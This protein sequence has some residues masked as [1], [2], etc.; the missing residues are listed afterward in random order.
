MNTTPKTRPTRENFQRIRRAGSFLIL[1]LLTVQ[2]GQTVL[3]SPPTFRSGKIL[4]SAAS[5]SNQVTTLQVSESPAGPWLDLDD[6]PG[7]GQPI[8]F[9]VT[10]TGERRFFRLRTAASS[11]FALSPQTPTLTTGA[12]SLPD[13]V[14]GSSYAENISTAATGTPPYTFQ[15]SGTPPDGVTLLLVSNGTANAFL[16]ISA[17]GAGA[18]A[19]QRRQFTVSALDGA[20]ALATNLYDLRVIEPPPVILTTSILLK[21]GQDFTTSLRALHGTGPLDWSA[22]SEIM[23]AGSSLSATGDLSGLPSPDDAEFEET[24]RFTNMVMVT[25]S[26]TDRISG[27]PAPRSTVSAVVVTVRLSY[28]QNIWA[29]RPNGPSLGSICYFCHGSGFPP[30]VTETATTLIGMGS[31]MGSI[32]A[33]SNQVYVVPGNP[34]GS[35]VWKKLHGPD[36]GDRMPQ[37][38]PYLEAGAIARVERWIRELTSEDID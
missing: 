30:D 18:V 11:S 34:A 20:G 25:D 37:G 22:I 33:C 13:A 32:Y 6:Y 8:Q 24:G 16:R 17:T 3:I 1:F 19:G 5:V 31:Q 15:V 12:I 4:F 10:T 21:A 26:H 36:C 27:A 7:T 9:S 23:P 29:E 38:G 14:V 2:A 35:L 28:Q